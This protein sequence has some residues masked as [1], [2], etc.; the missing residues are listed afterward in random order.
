MIAEPNCSKRKCI[1]FLGVAQ[2]DG[3]E[4]TERVICKA[5]PKGIPEEIAYGGNLHVKPYPGDKGIQFEKGETK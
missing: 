1:H 5:F 2:P 4:M 3:T